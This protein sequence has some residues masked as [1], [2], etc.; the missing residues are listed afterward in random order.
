MSNESK[1]ALSTLSS[2]SSIA[3]KQQMDE[4]SKISELLGFNI[5]D[6]SG[7]ERTIFTAINE[8]D[9]DRLLAV[10][11][12][13]PSSTEILQMLLTT[14]YPNRDGFYK[15]DPDVIQDAHELLGPR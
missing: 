12:F 9:R 13:H 15:H 14:S 6:P 11:E 8:G 2:L 4:N 1:E 10:F 5:D 7:L 3:D